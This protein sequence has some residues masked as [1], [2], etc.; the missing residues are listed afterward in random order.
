MKDKKL[1]LDQLAE[2]VDDLIVQLDYPGFE[3]RGLRLG[4]PEEIQRL[5]TKTFASA[6]GHTSVYVR[7]AALRWFQE[8]PGMAKSY[9]KAVC[10][11]LD[12][13]DEFL[14]MEAIKTVEKMHDVP[15]ETVIEIAKLLKDN[16]TE[17]RK[18]VAKAVGKLGSRLKPKSQEVLDAL[19]EA[20]NDADPEVRMKV[21]KAVR[22]VSADHS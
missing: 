5:S 11:L 4:L 12:N 22:L 3:P 9:L 19:Q 1:E 2:V 20:T 16:H 15:A 18:A 7:L 8:H 17:V 10:G 21:Q 14:R 13:D 6:L